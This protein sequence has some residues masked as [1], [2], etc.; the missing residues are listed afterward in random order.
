[1]LAARGG[2]IGVARYL[3]DGGANINSV[4]SP[5]GRHYMRRVL[6]VMQESFRSC[7]REAQTSPLS[8]ERGGL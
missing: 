3:L 1:M 7:C 2:H 4:P 5:G 8:Q 6:K